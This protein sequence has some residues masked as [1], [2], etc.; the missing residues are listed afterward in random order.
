MK[1]KLKHCLLAVLHACDGLPMPETALLSAVH[2]HARPER[3]SDSDILDALVDLESKGYA[4]GLTD[5]LTNERTWT[6][7][8]KG[9]HK[10]R[11]MRGT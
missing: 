6:L 5:G 9:T 8:G 2:L 4:A 11:E 10:A 1:S 7:T 3:P